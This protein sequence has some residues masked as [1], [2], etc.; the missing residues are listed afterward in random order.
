[1]KRKLTKV[2]G[3]LLVFASMFPLTSQA[4][5][6]YNLNASNSSSNP[7]ALGFIGCKGQGYRM[8]SMSSPNAGSS[9]IW[10][11]NLSLNLNEKFHAE[12]KIRFSATKAGADGI[13][14]MLQNAGL[15]AL[16]GN[17]GAMG[18]LNVSNSVG[19]E[20]DIFTNTTLGDATTD[21]HTALFYNGNLANPLAGTY[22][23][24]GGGNIEDGQW[25]RVVIDWNP[26]ANKKEQ[27]LSLTFDGKGIFTHTA[28]M[29]N[30]V[31]GGNVSNITWGFTAGQGTLH[32]NHDLCIVRMTT[33]DCSVCNDLIMNPSF[34]DVASCLDVDFTDVSTT[35]GGNFASVIWDFGDGTTMN[36]GVGGTVSHTYANPGTYNVCLT[37]LVY[38][39]DECCHET[40]CRTIVVEACDPCDSLIFNPGFTSMNNNCLT[41]SFTDVSTQTGGVYSGVDWDFGDG[42]TTTS[43][44]GGTVSHTYATSGTYTVCLTMTVTISGVKCYD[45]LC[46]D[47][48][49]ADDCS[50]VPDPDFTISTN[51]PCNNGGCCVGTTFINNA[52]FAPAYV[53][54]NW[55]DG[56]VAVPD[57]NAP[58]DGFHQYASSGTYLITLTVI[59][60]P[61][62]NPDVCCV[63]TIQKFVF[64]SCPSKTPRMHVNDLGNVG[65]AAAQMTAFP[66]PVNL[67]NGA[68]INVRLDGAS[69]EPIQLSLIDLTG[70][71]VLD[72]QVIATAIGVYQLELSADFGPGVY[73]VR[74]ANDKGFVSM[75]KLVISE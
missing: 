1:M 60:H 33:E 57:Y 45:T 13:T 25:H 46:M 37:M 23:P 74:A 48:T 56:S 10:N 63:K 69:D 67:K 58:F 35:S 22:L 6:T 71:I 17:G 9:S 53:T 65:D 16:G 52:G 59:Y 2:L 41:A 28:D 49:V 4:Q 51:V 12:F 21:N 70:K 55:G 68:V 39:G 18:A 38:E 62:C 54:W 30:S 20:F 26:C 5:L 50:T 43:A 73:M 72:Q 32:S 34:T 47:I 61:P 15:N 8:L 29:I 66:N 42:T 75:T 14:F 24:L 64:V 31:F 11:N 40:S 3:L 19:V 36:G 27:S 7:I 44:P